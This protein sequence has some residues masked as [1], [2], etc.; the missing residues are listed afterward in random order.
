M[1]VEVATYIN[2]LDP[3]S[4]AGTDP[5][6]Q[7][8][9]HLRTIKSAVKQTFPNV[10][11]AVNASH[12][13]LNHLVGVTSAVQ[14]QIDLK[15]SKTG[16]SYTGIHDFSLATGVKL[17]AATTI[18]AVTAAELGYLSGV[19]S[20]IQS[21]FSGVSTAL[22]G[23]VSRSGDTY[24]GSH[25]MT[26][27]VVTVVTQPLTDKST[28]AASTKHVDDAITAA[29][30]SL[31]LPGQAGNAGK[32]LST[33]GENAGWANAPVV[34]VM[35]RAGDVTGLL[36]GRVETIYGKSSPMTAAPLWKWVAYTALDGAN[37]DWPTAAPVSFWIVFTKGVSEAGNDR[38]EQ[39]AEQI[40]TQG[41]QGFTFKRVK[42]DGTWSRWKRVLTDDNIVESD[43]GGAISTST[44]LLDPSVASVQHKSLSANTTISLPAAR[45]AG[46]QATLYLYQG[47]SFSFAFASNIFLPV[48]VT[49]EAIPSGQMLPLYFFPKYAGSN[50]WCVAP[51]TRYQG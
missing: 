12:V 32:Y 9:D 4:P 43:A 37:A 26:G 27:A 13:E 19:T 6:S 42:H 49:L 10:A 50:Q 2:Q 5:K 34:S 15:A 38:F 8:D 25:V 45:G 35:G 41:G 17:P 46:D 29:A 22:T 33:D 44:F 1:P 39:T 48:G 3:L 23:K 21:Q 51:G 11:G 16:D 31:S 47:G 14:P 28:K 30:L 20:A 7:G 24:T 40:Y 36:D 18:G